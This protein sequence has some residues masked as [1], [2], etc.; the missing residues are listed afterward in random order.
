MTTGA[1]GGAP[2]APPPNPSP[3]AGGG[4]KAPSEGVVENR[5]L[6]LLACA[7]VVCAKTGLT[8]AIAIAKAAITR[9]TPRYRGASQ[10]FV[11]RLADGCAAVISLCFSAE[12]AAISSHSMSRNEQPRGW[13][14]VPKAP[15]RGGSGAPRV[16]IARTPSSPAQSR[17]PKPSASCGADGRRPGGRIDHRPVRHRP[18]R[19]LSHSARIAFAGLHSMLPPTRSGKRHKVAVVVS[20][21]VEENAATART[22][23]RQAS[24]AHHAKSFVSCTSRKRFALARTR[25]IRICAA[26]RFGEAIQPLRRARPTLR[27]FCGRSGCASI[28]PRLSALTS[29]LASALRAPA[30][31]NSHPESHQCPTPWNSLR[32]VG[33]LNRS[34]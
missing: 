16:L 17:S 18:D 31:A 15:G 25:A 32:L 1:C 12:I 4:A 5:E 9:K 19:P 34:R 7:R 10:N 30:S 20:E 6:E 26:N 24:G 33:R 28:A 21:F 3:R 2:S 11:R 29:A 13:P 22:L 23:K 14:L 27:G 8:C